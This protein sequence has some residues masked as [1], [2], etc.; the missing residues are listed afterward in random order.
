MSKDRD[1]N[2]KDRPVFFE[3]KKYELVVYSRTSLPYGPQHIHRYVEVLYVMSGVCQIYLEGAE[4]TVHTD[5]AVIVFPNQVHGYES[6]PETNH[7]IVLISPD[8]VPEYTDLFLRSLPK[9]S[10]FIGLASTPRLRGYF[11]AVAEIYREKMPNREIAASGLM[12]AFFSEIFTG[13]EFS[14]TSSNINIPQAI[15]AFCMENYQKPITLEMLSHMLYV[16]PNYISR[17]FNQ[18]LCISL[19]DYVNYLRVTH[20]KQLLKETNFPILQ[21]AEDSGFRSIRTL[22]HVFHKTTGKTPMEYRKG[23]I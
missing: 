10:Y 8:L 3:S 1:K 14:P 7:V 21:I 12:T 23:K 2:E 17:I 20:A 22:D 6:G 16:S 5:E 11:N 13:V 4:Y 19:T 15:L 9:Q 18:R